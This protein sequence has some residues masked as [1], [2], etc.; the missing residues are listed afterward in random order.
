MRFIAAFLAR[1]LVADARSLK[2]TATRMVVQPA[3]YL[4]VFGYVVGRMLPAQ[5][6][7]S[8]AEV[9][10]PGIIAIAILSG[11]FVTVGGSILSGYYFRTLEGWLLA[12]VSLRTLMLAHVAGGVVYGVAGGAVVALLVWVILGIAPESLLIPLVLGVAGA[13]LFSLLSLLVLLIPA[14]PDK[15]QEF[16]SLLMMPLT[17][18]GCTFYSYSML[19]PPFTWLA[20]LLPTTYLSEGLRAAYNPATAHMG[21]AAVAAGLIAAAAL[22]FP[23]AEWAFRRRLRDFTW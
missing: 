5:G 17:F 6:G 20:L 10:A 4:F 2:L 12:P 14:T 9:M 16:F 21:L 3:I 18:F 8:Y 19:E 1:S 13:L 11:P 7:G 23:L 22:L 15:G